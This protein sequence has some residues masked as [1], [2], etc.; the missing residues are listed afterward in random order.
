MNP[1]FLHIVEQI[2]EVEKPE[3]GT[4]FHWLNRTENEPWARVL[5]TRDWEYLL[6]CKTWEQF[7]SAIELL[8]PKYFKA[9][10]YVEEPDSVEDW[11]AR[12]HYSIVGRGYWELYGVEIDFSSVATKKKRVKVR[13]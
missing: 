2:R 4:L 5:D 10:K 9:W 7:T 3:K 6:S 1:H 11:L 12:T 8:V 13:S